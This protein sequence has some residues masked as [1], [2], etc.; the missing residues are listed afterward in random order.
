MTVAPLSSVRRGEFISH[1]GESTQRVKQAGGRVI[2]A[3]GQSR[4]WLGALGLAAGA[5]MAMW[6]PTSRRE[7]EIVTQARDDILDKAEE[8]GHRAAILCAS[9]RRPRRTT[10]TK[11]RRARPSIEAISAFAQ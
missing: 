3:A 5:A 8:L 4:W 6:L 10:R 1:P 9:S 11:V 7:R 2:E